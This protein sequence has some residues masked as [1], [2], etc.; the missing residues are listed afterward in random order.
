[1]RFMPSVP[2]FRRFQN[3]ISD[4]ANDALSVRFDAETNCYRF[5]FASRDDVTDIFVRN[6]VF[7]YGGRFDFAFKIVPEDVDIFSLPSKS[8]AVDVPLA[9]NLARFLGSE[10]LVNFPLYPRRKKR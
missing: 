8:C 4:L 6:Q 1:M 9:P 7:D 5:F 3:V 10:S 2:Y